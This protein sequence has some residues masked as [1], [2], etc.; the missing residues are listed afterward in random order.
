MTIYLC[1]PVLQ[2]NTVSKQLKDQMMG[3]LW[4]DKAKKLH[5]MAPSNKVNVELYD[6]V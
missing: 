3:E 4:S 5:E 6:I 2:L 1:E